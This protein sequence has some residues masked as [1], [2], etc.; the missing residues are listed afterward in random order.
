MKH[1]R[2]LV[3]KAQCIQVAPLHLVQFSQSD[4][5]GDQDSSVVLFHLAPNVSFELVEHATDV[6]D[7]LDA[8]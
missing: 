5:A 7:V 6:V 8:C 2:R 3:C 1:K 4:F